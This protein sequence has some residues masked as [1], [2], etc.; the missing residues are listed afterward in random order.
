MNTE[1]YTNVQAHMDICCS[2]TIN[3]L[4]FRT[5]FSF[6]SQDKSLVIGVEIHK[7]LVRIANRKEP[8]KA[9][10]SEAV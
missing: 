2:S 1:D 9:A 4:T 7:M 3:V 8:D 10:S 6:C 5:L